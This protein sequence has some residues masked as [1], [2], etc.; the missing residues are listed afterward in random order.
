MLFPL[1]A[2]LLFVFL[3]QFRISLIDRSLY[4][5]RDDGVITLSHGKN[6]VDFGFI[7]VNPSGG[8]VEGYSAPLQLGI[9]TLLYAMTGLSYPSFFA[10]QILL[11]TF[12]LG[13]IMFLFFRQN[14]YY[15]FGAT[16]IT[17]LIL[18]SSTEFMEWHYSGMENP[19]THLTTLWMLFLLWEMLRT[20]HIQFAYIAVFFLASICRA[21]SIAYVFPILVVFTVGWRIENKNWRGFFFS[22]AVLATWGTYMAARTCYFGDIFPNTA[23]AQGISVSHRLTELAGFHFDTYFYRSTLAAFRKVF[24]SSN[25]FLLF[26]VLIPMT[27]LWKKKRSINV[28]FLI[29]LFT[30]ILTLFAFPFLFGP[31]RLDPVRTTTQLTVVTAL[32][33]VC[34]IYEIG[35]AFS[36]K[37][38][39]ALALIFLTAIVVTGF[40][41][42]K[43][44]CCPAESF[45]QI[46]TEF[47][48]M[49]DQEELPR[50]E[51]CNPD[52]GAVSFH[53]S[54]NILD[55][56]K[57][58]SPV[59]ARIHNPKIVANYFFNYIAPD[60]IEAHTYWINRYR[61]IFDDP[62]F[63]ET[64][65][66]EKQ[67][68]NS[69][70]AKNGK[71]AA[72]VFWIRK[73]ICLGCDSNERKLIDRLAS[74][75]SLH[76]F[77]EELEKC[78][79]GETASS[80]YVTRTAFRFLPE[81]KK[82]GLYHDVLKLFAR[83]KTHQFDLALLQSGEMPGWWRK[84]L[85]QL[86]TGK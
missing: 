12:A 27:L 46:Y 44:L 58:G 13:F 79:Y 47:E 76:V 71:D 31:A 8:R 25:S 72:V 65:T 68:H 22:M 78:K 33:I 3:F 5:A 4:Q 51:I 42:A 73:N 24:F 30:M 86:G 64:Y 7:G 82:A 29:I 74:G 23:Y 75:M 70:F 81:L 1:L 56:G 26:L 32:T 6:W 39:I 9:F 63:L 2:G 35:K 19:L 83:T 28:I 21:E 48:W 49:K 60:F 14:V 17:A 15:G 66:V 41:P 10:I 18:I 57:L 85:P 52:L 67:K 36:W 80:L 20:K 16:A 50:P 45:E 61:F 59:L 69:W 38:S 54:F 84:I 43:Y 62:R 40:A 77:Q 53:K 34:F 11:A 55:L 37:V